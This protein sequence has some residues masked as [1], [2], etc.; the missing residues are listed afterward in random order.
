MTPVSVI[1]DPALSVHT[2]A[3]LWLS[4]GIR[5]VDH[6]VEG[7]CSGRANAFADAQADGDAPFLPPEPLQASQEMEDGTVIFAFLPANASSS[8]IS[9]L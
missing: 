7:V 5:A 8:V 6:C 3:W 9:M 1:L 4:T 2:P